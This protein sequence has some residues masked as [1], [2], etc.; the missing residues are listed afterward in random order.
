MSCY[1]FLLISSASPKLFENKKL[2]LE[3]KEF[4][5]TF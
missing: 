4:I 3:V 2:H 1:D 5:I